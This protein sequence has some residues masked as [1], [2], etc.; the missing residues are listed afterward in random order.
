MLFVFC[1]VK[2]P[3]VG[4]IKTSYSELCFKLELDGFKKNENSLWRT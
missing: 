3:V 1:D 4:L 2:Y